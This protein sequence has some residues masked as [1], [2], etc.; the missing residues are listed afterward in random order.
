MSSFLMV[1]DR[2]I[3][4][5]RVPH[6]VQILINDVGT[7]FY[8]I[9]I[10]S[11]VGFT[12]YHQ[13]CA[14]ISIIVDDNMGLIRIN[15]HKFPVLPIQMDAS[16]SDCTDIRADDRAFTMDTAEPFLLAGMVVTSSGASGSD[17]QQAQLTELYPIVSMCQLL[18]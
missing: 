11:V 3:S 18:E 16:L 5:G 7:P 17:C 10:V 8:R 2:R 15:N 1:S 6:I 12:A 4:S 14:F 9:S 13:Q